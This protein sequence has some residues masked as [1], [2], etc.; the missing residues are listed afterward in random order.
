MKMMSSDRKHMIAVN[1][2]F[3]GRQIVLPDELRGVPPGKVI[4][5]FE[6]AA[7]TED[8]ALWLKA[9]EASFAKAWDNAEDEVYD[10]M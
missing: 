1:A 4:V 3:D 6:E 8:R 10:R 2:K 5:I 7:D 9:Q